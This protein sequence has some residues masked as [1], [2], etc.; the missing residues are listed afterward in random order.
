MA[1]RYSIARRQQDVATD[2]GPEF[3]VLG[4]LPSEHPNLFFRQIRSL[5]GEH[6]GSGKDKMV[7]MAALLDRTADLESGG[8]EKNSLNG[9]FQSTERLRH[10]V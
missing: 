9:I 3:R 5:P 7:S 4:E 10:Y 6:E 1:R 8:D 2:S